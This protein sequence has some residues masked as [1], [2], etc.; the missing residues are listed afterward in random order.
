MDGGKSS[1]EAFCTSRAT[2]H[3]SGKQPA[4]LMKISKA[5]LPR[6][7]RRLLLVKGKSS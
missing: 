1:P 6:M 3:T 2:L 7:S 4:Q 5:L